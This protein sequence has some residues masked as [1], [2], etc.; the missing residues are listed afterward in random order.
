MVEPTNILK[1][2][3]F[4]NFSKWDVK[5]FFIKQIQSSYPVLFL[6]ELLNEETEKKKLSKY[7]EE[8]FGILGVSNE[9]GMLDA[10]IEKGK[11]I[12][13]PYKFVKNDFIAYNPYRVNVGSI[14]I[15]K[16]F[17]KNTYISNAYVVFSTKEMLLADYLYLLMHTS[18]FNQLIRDNT[19]GSVRQTL[20]FENLCKIAVPVPA[21][22]EQKTIL[23]KYQK[24]IT[25]AESFEKK[26]EVLN[27]SIEH[28][29]KETIGIPTIND[30]IKATLLS[31]GKFSDLCEKWTVSPLQSE[32]NDKL[33]L[34][35]Y[36]LQKVSVLNCVTRT[37][38]KKQNKNT[39][40][41][42]I[43][44]G[45]IN[46]E[47]G[48]ITSEEIEV[49]KAPSRATQIVHTGD[50][51]FGMTRPYLKKFAIVDNEHDGFVCSSG[52][53]VIAPSEEYNLNY[54][55]EVFKS[56]ICISQFKEAMTGALYPALN[57]VQLGNIIIPLPPLPVQEEI[58]NHINEIKAQIK[59][60]RRQALEL[61][62]QA[63]KDFEGSVFE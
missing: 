47:T 29:L 58:V 33:R 20:S 50:L 1:T 27:F 15:K 61:R 31:F 42:Y 14:G 25:Q 2:V 51:I 54:I 7:P 22:S 36:K 18:K 59:E 10:Y 45:G 19:T 56:N 37:W 44:I 52:F 46:S 41:N 49:S 35:K 26:A 63:K 3:S 40:F 38:K 12:K 9:V 57:A 24:T 48:D 16:G 8:D 13:Q 23:Q 4:R 11:N 6:S 55:L 62:E 43:E 30:D 34:S 39:F 21:V 17:L 60:L 32:I 5:R 53:Q 28:Y